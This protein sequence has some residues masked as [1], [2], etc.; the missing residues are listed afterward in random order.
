MRIS[1][2]PEVYGEVSSY[3]ALTPCHA[4]NEPC[5]NMDISSQ[6]LETGQ[7]KP[8]TVSG[9]ISFWNSMSNDM[10]MDVTPPPTEYGKKYA[11]VME[12][13]FHGLKESTKYH[14]HVFIYPGQ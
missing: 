6:K 4:Q 8:K 5:S 2:P 13:G 10:D 1:L 11:L 14:G 3:I 12:W 9:M 7:I